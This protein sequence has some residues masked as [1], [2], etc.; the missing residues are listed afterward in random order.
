M[1]WLKKWLFKKPVI[2]DP[3]H[4]FDDNGY[5]N[6]SSDLEHNEA[7]LKNIFQNCSDIVY[8]KI[9]RAGNIQ[10]LVV[11]LESLVDEKLLDDHVLQPLIAK[12]SKQNVNHEK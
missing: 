9:A 4:E 2:L 11:Y 6:L 1:K 3:T 12:G 5:G 10:W 7:L 8:R